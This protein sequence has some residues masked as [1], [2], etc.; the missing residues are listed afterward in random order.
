MAVIEKEVSLLP[1]QLQLMTSDARVAGLYTARGAGKTFYLSVEAMVSLVNQERCI[2]FA[3]THGALIMNIFAAIMKRCE[4]NGIPAEFNEGKKIITYG[5]GIIFGFSYENVDAVRGA[6]EIHKLLLDEIATAPANLL[7]V[8]APCL[9]GVG[10]SKI[11]FASTPR[12]GSYW[13][14][15]I[16]ETPEWFVITGIKMTD[17]TKLSKEDFDLM[18]SAIKDEN[19]Y[20]QEVLGEIL[21]DDIKF[22]VIS[23]KDYPLL[24]KGQSGIRKMGIDCSGSGDDYN[25]FVVSD[26]NCI[27]EIYK[28]QKCDTYK[29]FAIAKDLIGK[30]DV[31]MVNIDTTGG[32]GNGLYD[33]LRLGYPKVCI[34]GINFGQKSKSD[35]YANA[36]AEMYFEMADKVRNGFYVGNT[37]D[38]ATIREELSFTSYNVNST[39]KTILVKKEAIKEI[40]GHSPDTT[41]AFV[42]SLYEPSKVPNISPSESLQ[43]ALKF[44]SF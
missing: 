17:N 32:F 18:Q 30:W 13:D 34:N 27:L 37:G 11:R 5:K 15:Q 44:S 19:Q 29:Q 25:V 16:K 7:S 41:D 14:R 36:R 3:Q 6:T 8:A 35:S 23:N 24:N 40:L 12:K 4:E 21:D 1:W 42:L 38:E 33:M 31:K 43:V 9:R 22:C 2:I 10:G 39:G 28:E 26:D 20:R